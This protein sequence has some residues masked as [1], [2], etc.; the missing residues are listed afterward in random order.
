[1]LPEDTKVISVDDHIIEPPQL[2]LD[3]VPAKYGDAIPQVVRQ[4]DGDYWRYDDELVKVSKMAVVAGTNPE[5]WEEG[6]TTFEIA[7]RGTWDPVA[8]LKDM[9]ADGVWASV[10]FPNYP[11]FAGHHFLKGN[12]RELA[13]AC[14]QAW[15]DFVLDEW[16]AADPERFIPLS[17]VPLWDS[18]LAVQEIQRVAAKGSRAVAFSEDPEMLG[19]PSIWTGYWDDFVGAVQDADIALCMHIG[20]SSKLVKRDL[21][22]RTPGAVWA[23]LNSMNSMS[24]AADWV[25]SG[26]L[27][28]HPRLR[29]AFSEGG[30]GWA[31][32]IM[33]RMDYTWDHRKFYSGV[34]INARPS[35][36]FRKHVGLCFLTDDVAI[37]LRH[38][39]GVEMLMFESDFP[40]AESVFPY[41]RKTLS[42][43]LADVPDDEARLIAE[44]NARRFFRFQ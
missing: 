18:D 21:M 42:E 43:S 37:K 33:E 10:C 7:R 3:R 6:A 5:N 39:I 36:L 26:L 41:S 35:E 24:A 28:K 32:H 29:I 27:Q 34:D 30:A 44:G 22:S 38:E 1:M 13:L 11:R 23:S 14:V 40:H 4:P 25:F 15:N 19:L 9:D 17:I 31:P 8:R 12:S 16:C 2:W 20:S